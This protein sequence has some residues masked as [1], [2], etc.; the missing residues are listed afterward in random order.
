MNKVFVTIILSLLFI[1]TSN[2]SLIE[3]HPLSNNYTFNLDMGIGSYVETTSRNDRLNASAMFFAQT[4]IVSILNYIDIGFGVYVPVEAIKRSR[5]MFSISYCI[6]NNNFNPGIGV[7]VGA[8]PWDVWGIEL[9][10]FRK[11]F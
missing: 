8:S 7:Y 11:S 9:I 10:L 4:P 3:F 6:E 5:P 2:A 1:F